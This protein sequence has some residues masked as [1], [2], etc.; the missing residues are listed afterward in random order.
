MRRLSGILLLDKPAGITSQGAI[1][2]LRRASGERRVGH[3]GTLDPLATGLLPVLFGP[4]TR[5]SEYLVGHDKRYL[6]TARLGIETATYDSD[7]D[8][9]ATY[10]GPLPTDAE[11]D[12]AVC[13]LVG[14]QMQ[15]PPAY[16]AVKVG[17]QPLYRRARRGEAVILK[18]RAVT[19]H[20][21][22]WQRSSA[23]T[24]SLQVHCSAGTYVR[25]LVHD[26]GVRLGC[27]AHVSALRRVA[28]GGFGV[29][30][31]LGLA[32]AEAI[33]RLGQLPSMLSIAE[34]LPGMPRVVFDADDGSRLCRGQP[35]PGAAP[36]AEGEHLALDSRGQALAVVVY[37]TEAGRW[38]ASKVF[39]QGVES[40][41]HA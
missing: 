14:P 24:I 7:G 5:I 26:L 13:S 8:V 11:V 25:S 23:E 27:G 37:V 21:L 19:V 31:A 1:A 9:T 35:V 39:V 18:A 41:R 17:G 16:S 6:V 32:E 29:E 15:V 40:C 4:A 20:S 38:R 2:V 33:F 36:A 28:V 34:A 22:C 30:G 10:T 12:E 3:A